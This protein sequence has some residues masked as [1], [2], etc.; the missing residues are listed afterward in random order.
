MLALP[1]QVAARVLP[2][3]SP[4]APPA[5]ALGER[6]QMHLPGVQFYFTEPLVHPRFPAGVFLITTP[7]LI[8]IEPQGATWRLEA[9][10]AAFA[11]A[12]PAQTG[13][14]QRGA[15][16]AVPGYPAVAAAKDAVATDDSSDGAAWAVAEGAWPHRRLAARYGD[17]SVCDVW[18]VTLCDDDRASPVSELRWRECASAGELAAEVWRQ[19]LAADG[20]AFAAQVRGARSGRSLATLGAAV[21]ARPPHLWPAFVDQNT[22][23]A[24]PCDDPMISANAGT[25]ALRPFTRSAHP[26]LFWAGAH[27]RNRKEMTRMDSAVESGVAAA[28][29]ALARVPR[30]HV[31]ANA[32]PR[33]ACL[34]DWDAG[35][36]AGPARLWPWLLLPARTLDRALYALGLP[37]CFRLVTALLPAA[38]VVALV[39]LAALLLVL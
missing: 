1:P 20:G 11:T 19:V 17:G 5:K 2:A 13:G 7:W 35:L 25:R 3:D 28:E 38:S 34:A 15:R 10:Q 21:W 36:Q 9:D 31:C 24:Q 16:P 39:A 4:E 22:G 6:A 37:H 30:A 23:H 8:T 18:S 14:P 26:G 33:R 29:A 12:R 27:A 32:G